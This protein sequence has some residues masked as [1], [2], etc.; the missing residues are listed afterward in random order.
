[1]FSRTSKTIS[2]TRSDLFGIYFPLLLTTFIILLTESRSAGL[3]LFGL[4]IPFYFIQN[5]KT[6][7][8]YFALLLIPL[9]Y[10]LIPNPPARADLSLS[11]RHT[12]QGVSLSVVRAFPIFGTGAQA[13]ISTYPSVAPDNRLL[14]PDHNSFTLFLSWFGPFGVLATILIL[15]S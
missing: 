3:A 10:F 15:K 7:I 14:Q 11:E 12:L 1:M 8:M 9:F 5:L 2:E 6:R 13:S 4:V